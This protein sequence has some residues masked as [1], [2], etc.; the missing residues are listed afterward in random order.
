MPRKRAFGQSFREKVLTPDGRI[1]RH[2]MRAL[3]RLSRELSFGSSLSRK[4]CEEF[5]GRSP[6]ITKAQNQNAKR[7]IRAK[8][9]P[10]N[11]KG[12]AIIINKSVDKTNVHALSISVK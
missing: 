3:N 8:Q 10:A 9:T 6:S 11:K 7:T 5:E 2:K 12:A 1:S 4:A